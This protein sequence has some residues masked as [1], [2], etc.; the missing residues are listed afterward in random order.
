MSLYE[1]C[2]VERME[3][4]DADQKHMIDVRRL[5]GRIESYPGQHAKGHLFQEHTYLRVFL[6]YVA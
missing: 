5:G 2:N 1:I 4:V 3:T 6:V